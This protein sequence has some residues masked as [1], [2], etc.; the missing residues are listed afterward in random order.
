[1]R[2]V[3]SEEYFF[4]LHYITKP[5]VYMTNFVIPHKC[6]LVIFVIC[7]KI[8]NKKYNKVGTVP[9]SNRQFVETESKLTS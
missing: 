4:T 5:Y 8:E 1:M 2:S 7:N 6:I 3:F 9:K